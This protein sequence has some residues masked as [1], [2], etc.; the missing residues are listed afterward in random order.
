MVSGKI[1]SRVPY[2]KK[3]IVG[4]VLDVLIQTGGQLEA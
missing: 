2:Q 3:N 1:R 4:A